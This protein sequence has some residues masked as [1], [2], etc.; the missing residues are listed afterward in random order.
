MPDIVKRLRDYKIGPLAHQHHMLPICHEAA[1]EITRLREENK[2]LREIVN[3][4][5]R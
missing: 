3:K 4:G 1:D 5:G 2:A